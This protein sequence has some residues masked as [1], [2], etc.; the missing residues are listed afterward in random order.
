MKKGWTK[1]LLCFLLS[2]SIWLVYNLSQDYPDTE[3]TPVLFRSRLDGR[4]ETA[5]GEVLVSARCNTTGFNHI[6][7]SLRRKAVKVDVD[8]S[9]FEYSGGDTYHIPSANLY[10]YVSKIFGDDVNIE[11]FASEGLDVVFDEVNHR[12]VPVVVSH[13][14]TFKPQYMALGPIAVEPDS[15]VVYGD[16]DRISTIESVYTRQL[17]LRELGKNGARGKVRLER[18]SGVMV[19][20]NEVSYSIPVGR[21]VE[22]RSRMSVSVRNVPS[23]VDFVVL[24]SSVDVVFRCEFPLSSDPLDIVELYVDYGEFAN[25][26]HGTCMVHCDGIPAGV[27]DYSVDPQVCECVEHVTE[28]LQSE[29]E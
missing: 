6:G 29:A 8:P 27:I 3:T 10:K 13:S 28:P 11:S 26:I 14:V 21:Y 12:K 20:L 17:R 18:P 5:S 1:F 9:D 23:G 24:P 19:S 16:P 4:A 2:A 7:L 25:S 22:L 15:V